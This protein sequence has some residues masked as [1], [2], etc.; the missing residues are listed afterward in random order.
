MCFGAVDSSGRTWSG[1][2]GDVA[3]EGGDFGE[4]EVR[5]NI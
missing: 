1:Y 4:E 5:K 3:V 2:G